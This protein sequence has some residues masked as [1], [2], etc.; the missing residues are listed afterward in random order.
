MKKILLIALAFA[1]VAG[2]ASC[3]KYKGYKKTENGLYYKFLVK[4]DGEKPKL[5]DLAMV[6]IVL[7]R[8]DTVMGD[9][10][11]QYTPIMLNKGSFPGDLPE[12]ILLMG[13]GDS[14]S[15]ILNNDTLEKYA[16]GQGM[17]DVKME[18]LVKLHKFL[19]MEEYQAEQEAMYVEQDAAGEAQ[20]QEALNAYL[21]K[22]NITAKPGTD[23][24]IIMHT[25]KGNGPLVGAGKHVKV[26]YTGKLTD[27][28][29]FD[30][31]IE[32]IAA[33][34]G[35]AFPQREYKPIEF[36]TA[37]PGMIPGFDKAVQQMNVGGKATVIIP[38]KQAYGRQGNSAV[39]PYSTL[40]FDLEVVEAK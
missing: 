15:F 38:S 33:D 37:E 16:P 8:N 22:K 10:T 21:K 4:D 20:E 25:K 40:I 2:L 28:K 26:N 5:G 11:G 13:I 29:I 14:A 9:P 17:T 12:G 24:L 36:T 18:I 27:G 35:I 23:G 3:S 39:P 30:S 1:M 32:S 19:T 7:K 31:S 34:A 6:T